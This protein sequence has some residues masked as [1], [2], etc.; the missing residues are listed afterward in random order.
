M[1]KRRIL[2]LWKE[3][4][5]GLVAV[6]VTLAL[7]GYRLGSLAP[8]FSPGEL[9]AHQASATIGD[10]LS[11]P[12]HFPLKI[13]GWL[14]HAAP[15]SHAVTAARIPSVLFA[16]L[17][18]ALMVYI[19]K[20]WYGRRSMVFG[21]IIFICSAW[22]L[23]VGRYSGFEIDYILGILVLLAI[24]VTLQD[25]EENPYVFIGWLLTNI[26]LLFIPGF[27]W[28]VL[29]S[30]V[31]QFRTVFHAWQVLE[32][33]WTRGLIIALAVLGLLGPVV[34]II[35]TPS[36]LWPWLGLPSHLP[37]WRTLAS[38]LGHNVEAIAYMGPH[39]PELW[40]GQLPI[41]DIVMVGVPILYMIV[42]GGIAYLLYFWLRV[43][44]RNP[45]ARNV[46]L[47]L[48]C[49]VVGLSCIYN[50]SQYFIAWPHNLETAEAYH[51]EQR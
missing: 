32:A 36:L 21:F 9:R 38:N 31:W 42:V 19:L 5:L 29:L 6:A 20:R 30:M 37:L 33:A 17:A 39:R 45:L 14:A 11:N 1:I 41:L 28:F 50:L 16:L 44:P 46:G 4:G 12:M 43:F 22:L 7:L 2:G 10:I 24:H 18:V 49:I 26:V 23:H 34:S 3:F 25:N 35:W 48:I 8:H 15:H 51:L 47:G 13:L 27:V 40:L